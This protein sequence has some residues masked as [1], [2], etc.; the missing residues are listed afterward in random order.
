MTD[1][2]L[3]TDV[4]GST[5]MWEEFA[6]LMPELLARHD[7]IAHGAVRSAGGMVFKHV[8]D[9]MLAVF[10]EKRVLLDPPHICWYS[11]R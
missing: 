9:G 1:V 11:R 4:V 3:M 5:A 7:Q 8:G 6:E 10:D 2:F